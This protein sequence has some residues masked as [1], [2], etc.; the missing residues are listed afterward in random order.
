MHPERLLEQ[1][2]MFA[3]RNQVALFLLGVILLIGICL[4][5]GTWWPLVVVPV[6]LGIRVY[7]AR[8][9]MISS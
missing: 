5:M 8:K 9:G 7:Y 2:V 4:Q 3:N 6:G 1:P